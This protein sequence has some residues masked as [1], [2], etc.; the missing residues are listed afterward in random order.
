M[1]FHFFVTNLNLISSL[2]SEIAKKSNLLEPFQ[3]LAKALPITP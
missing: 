1:V 3:Q 2:G